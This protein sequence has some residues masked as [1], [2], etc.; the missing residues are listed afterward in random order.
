MTPSDVLKDYF[1]YDSFRPVQKDIIDVI[2]SG[3]DVMA[4]MPTGA[5]KSIC[6]QVPALLL[7]YGTVVISPLISLMKDQ[8]EALTA[9][10]LA[11]SYVNSTVPYK[12]SIERLRD[13][14]RGKL[15]LLYM[16]PEKLEPSYFT[17]C[18]LQVP[19]SMVVIDEAH[20]VSQWGHDFRPSYCRIHE[21]IASLP[22]R[23][24]VTAFT[25]TATP[26]VE[27]D[28][29]RSLALSDAAL[30]RTGLDR[31]NLS[32]RV[33]RDVNKKDFVLRY[34]KAHRRESGI[35]YCATRKAVDEVYLML[36][37]A[38]LA[39]GRYH[40]GMDDEERQQAQ[41]DFSYD[42]IMVMAAT[43]AFGMGIDKSNV[44]YVLHYQMPKSL[45]A[46]YQEAGRA[47]RDG[48]A[49]E[50][51]L[52]YGGQDVAIQKYLIEQG[53]QPD[54]QK[55][56]DYERLNRM[57][58]YCMTSSCLRN[59][60]L[61]YFGE[62]PTQP[63][64]HCGSCENKEGQVRVTDTAA[65]IFRTILATGERFGA[66][67][68]ADILKGSKSQRLK[69]RNLLTVPTYGKLSFEKLPH[70]RS[71]LNGYLADGYLIREGDPYPV[72]RLTE[73]ARD[74]LDGKADVY[75][76][77]T[78]AAEV[79]AD[80][81]VEKGKKRTLKGAAWELFEMLRKLRLAIAREERVPPFVVF[82]DATLEDMAAKAPATA[83]A[84]ASIRGVG[85]F[86][87]QKYGDRFLQAISKARGA[88]AGDGRE[89]KIEHTEKDA[90]A[91]PV[92]KKTPGEALAAEA[93]FQ[94][95][96]KK[97]R[98]LA[99]KEGFLPYRVLAD[100]SL[101]DMAEKKPE[102][103]EEMMA[104]HGM[105]PVKWEK[106][107][108]FF[109]EALSEAKKTIP[110]DACRGSAPAE[111]HDGCFLYLARVRSR[112]ARTYGVTD[113]AICQ[114]SALK[115]LAAGKEEALAGLLPAYRSALDDAMATYK[116][117]I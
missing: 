58:D 35:I 76:L 49:A 110:E 99:D 18:L 25:A 41:D 24:I 105:G 38:G 77:A 59:Y 103:K 55:R 100:S 48:A 113:E 117:L 97:R 82:S 89:E 109:L 4:I 87:L 7:P 9:Q 71:V 74:V 112:L 54:E 104:V 29:K 101:R 81:A 16:A 30:F 106:Y 26:Q 22:K 39:A 3:R 78:G 98:E 95:L 70:I 69:E 83:E 60:I 107:G 36:E 108:A 13:L 56:L 14:Y 10:G 8:V 12:E 11:A 90:A 40:A 37:E 115:A 88:A 17:Q 111:N 102:T 50:C 116:T 63:C 34:V 73:K 43:N 80:A 47:G 61:S 2:L 57:T 21:F 46:Y 32:F 65:L 33:I 72:L 62:R 79:I 1:G 6:F 20:C 27:A 28:M 93:L 42:R 31:P 67:V 64:G 94:F 45:E 23:P 68:I 44:R 53:N 86:K 91:V 84:M 19:L 66:S 75:G 51:V 5:G 52:L 92:K 85:T 114:D 15:K 96:R